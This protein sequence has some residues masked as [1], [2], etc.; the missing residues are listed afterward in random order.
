MKALLE[1]AGLRK[2][3]PGFIL[4]DVS[5]TL[6]SGYV[7]GLIGPNGAGK[8]TIIKLILNLV[9]RNAGEISIFGLDNESAEAQI[10]SRIGF[11][12]EVPPFYDH[13]TG[14]EFAK[15]VAPFY[16]RWNHSAFKQLC[17]EFELPLRKRIKALSRGMKMKL[18]LAIALSHGA[19]LLIMDEPTSGL[20]PVFRRELLD[21]FYEFLQNEEK[22]ILF[23]THITSDLERIADYITLVR[24]GEI[25]F[26][27][28][29]DTVRDRW[30]LVKGGKD[31]LSGDALGLLRAV[32]PHAFGFTALTDRAQEVKELFGSDV[33]I[34]KPSLGDLVYYFDRREGD[35]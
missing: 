7:M 19:D 6:P 9:K 1:V 31:L 33:V 28:P 4:K 23:S 14:T 8:T 21:K 10:K 13:L 24:D 3:Y 16:S 18:A 15:I 27:D 34:E 29:K 22:S 25:C 32:Q 12:H 11:V 35:A 5:F 2:E 20:D 17:E 30:A 26:S